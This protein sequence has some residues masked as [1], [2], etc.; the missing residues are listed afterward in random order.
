MSKGADL[1]AAQIQRELIAKKVL[2]PAHNC[3]YHYTHAV[4]LGGILREKQIRAT[5]FMHLN[6]RDEMKA[7]E[8]LVT[9]VANELCASGTLG[10]TA[11]GICGDFAKHYSERPLTRIVDVYVASL[12]EEGNDLG[13]WRA[14]GG[15]GGGYSIGFDTREFPIPRAGVPDDTIGVWFEKVEYDEVAMRALVHRELTSLL[16]SLARYWDTYAAGRDEDHGR[17]VWS[18]AMTVLVVEVGALVTRYKNKAFESEREWRIVVTPSINAP[19]G[20][21]KFDLR[22]SGIVPYINVPLTKGDAELAVRR[23]Y[24]GPTQ[25]PERGLF[26]ATQFAKE[27]GVYPTLVQ[28]SGIPLRPT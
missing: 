27:F 11:A 19:P 2:Q 4:G 1:I 14:Y 8:T 21:V 5:H 16:V 17:A 23:I 12:T 3:L 10:K 7:G 22:P 26:A 25:D 15:Q 18:S 13:Q 6:D 24:V 20:V 9:E 28:H